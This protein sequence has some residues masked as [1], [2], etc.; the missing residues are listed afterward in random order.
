VGAALTKPRRVGTARRRGC[1]EHGG[2]AYARNRRSYAPQ[3][4]TGS[5]L[6]DLG[7]RRRALVP[8]LRGGQLSRGFQRLTG[9]RGD[10]LRGSH[11]D[12][13]GVELDASFAERSMSEHG[14]RSGTADVHAPSAAIGLSPPSTDRVGSGRSRRSSPRPGEPVTWQRAAVVSRRDGGCNAERSATEW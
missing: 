1:G 4:G 3:G 6:A 7:R 2:K 11:G 12:V 10:V 13:A 8:S 9:G 14:N 5:N